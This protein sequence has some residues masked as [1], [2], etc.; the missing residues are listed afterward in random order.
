MTGL[1]IIIA[2]GVLV[3]LIAFA[4]V[5]WIGRLILSLLPLLIIASLLIWYGVNAQ[6]QVV[7]GM[8]LVGALAGSLL[9]IDSKVQ[10]WSIRRQL[11]RRDR[12]QA[13]G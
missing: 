7:A 9:L 1:T 6:W 8:V 12:A 4:I 3:G 10:N 13:V 5:S 2:L 11:D